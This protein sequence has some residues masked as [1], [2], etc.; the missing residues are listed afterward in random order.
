MFPGVN[1]KDMQKM[2]KKMGMEQQE[3][4]AKEVIIRTEE[5]DIIIKNPQVSK[6]NMMGQTT[7]QVVGEETEAKAETNEDD[8]Q[9]VMDQ[10]GVSKEFAEAALDDAKGDVAEAIIMLKEDK[11][12]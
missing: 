9:M 1:P 11:S 7:Y 6:V 5:G 10:A 4:P 2:M 12:A 8:I 3:I